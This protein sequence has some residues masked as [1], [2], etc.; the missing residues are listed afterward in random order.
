VWLRRS[1]LAVKPCPAL[2]EWPDPIW[3]TLR[4]NCGASLTTRLARPTE[5]L[6]DSFNQILQ[7]ERD[8][9]FVPKSNQ[10]VTGLLDA[11]VFPE[12]IG[13]AVAFSVV[14]NT[15]FENA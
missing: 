6:A 4:A 12:S 13:M 8:P 5:E 3:Q 9:F 2:P 10:T 1:Y 7:K 11:Q 15:N 14:V